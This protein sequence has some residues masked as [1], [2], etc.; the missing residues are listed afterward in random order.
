MSTRNI[1][2]TGASRGIGKAIALYFA[3]RGFN[4]AFCART[5]NDVD[6]LAQTLREF[7][8]D[9]IAKVVDVKNTSQIKEF[10][11]EV[12]TLWGSIDILINNA[13]TYLP[14]R[15][16]DEKEGTLETLIET[17]LYSAYYFSR[18]FAQKFIENKKGHIFNIASVAGQQA[19]P[20]GGS[21]SISKFAMIGLS[22]A[23]REE[24]KSLNVKVTTIS[25]GPVYTDSWSSAGIPEERFIPASDIGK[26]VFDLY[27]LSDTT[28]IEDLTVR[29]IL[30]D[31]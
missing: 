7:K 20:N 14:G 18:G 21:Y 26:L 27:H 9:V 29:P 11:D 19:Y 23:L 8:V 2:V 28:V 13:G 25:P 22:K 10:S 12:L 3:E 4:I 24:L 17:N 1:V 30:G 5:K 31:I 15:V 6:A 16:I